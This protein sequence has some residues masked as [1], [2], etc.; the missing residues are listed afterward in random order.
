MRQQTLASQLCLLATLFLL[1]ESPSRSIFRVGN[2]R[3]GPPLKRI[4][5]VTDFG[6][7]KLADMEERESRA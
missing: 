7:L 1:L 2:K 4:N 6:L 5:V 3:W